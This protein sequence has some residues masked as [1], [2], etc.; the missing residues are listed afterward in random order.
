MR[1]HMA[2]RMHMRVHMHMHVQGRSRELRK[3]LVVPTTGGRGIFVSP[4]ERGFDRT[5]PTK[6]EN[7]KTI[8]FRSVFTR[9]ASDEG[10]R[11]VRAE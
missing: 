2:T 5:R 11:C 10:K 9:P 7:R 6:N 3:W 1:M 4:L 8:R